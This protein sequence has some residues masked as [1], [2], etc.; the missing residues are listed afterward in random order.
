MNSRVRALL[1]LALLLLVGGAMSGRA[2]A[3]EVP[4][5]GGRVNDLAELLTGAA[6]ETLENQLEELEKATGVQIAVLTVPSLEGEVLEDY[7][8]RV[9]E[10][11]KLG[12]GE[13]D[14]GA[15][16][17]IARDERQMRLEVGYG[18]EGTIPDAYAKRILDDILRPRFRSGDFDGGIMA[19]VDAMVGLVEGEDSLPPAAATPQPPGGELGWS[20]VFGAVIFLLTV[21]TFSL[22]ALAARGCL[23]WFLYLF[24]MPF[25]FLFPMGMLGNPLGLILFGLWVV[26]FPILRALI[27]GTGVGRSWKGAGNG[28]FVGTGGGWSSS[29]GGWGGGFSGGGFSGGGGSFGGGGASGSW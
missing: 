15:L 22:Q 11:W 18:L 19:A 2:V 27:H 3:K 25:W 7:S 21:G 14:D 9:A 23:A 12:R 20:T 17:L 1:A 26:G 6:E 10:S 16:L 8:L 4:Y 13:F 28:P 5:L 24:L 29:R